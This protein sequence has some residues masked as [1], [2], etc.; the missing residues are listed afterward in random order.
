MKKGK[1]KLQ[2]N[3]VILIMVLGLVAAACGTSDDT[4]TTTVAP[5]TT[6]AAAATTTTAA[7]ETTTTEMVP[8]VCEATIGLMAPITGPVAFIGEVQL[9][10]AKYAVEVWNDGMGWD[11][12]LIEGDTMFDVAQAATL[13]AQFIDNTDIL[14]IVGPAGS[15]QVDAAGAVFEAGDANLTFISPSSTRIGIAEKYAG[16]FR[17]VPT[18]AD[19]GPSTSA[20]MVDAGASKVFMVDD[21]SSYS[22]GLADVTA[23]SLEAAGVEVVRESV[24]QVVTDF[25]ATYRGRWLPTARSSATRWPSR[26]RTSRSSA[27]TAWSPRTSLSPARSSP[28]SL[29]T[30]QGSRIRF[31][32]SRASSSSTRRPTRSGLRC[33]PR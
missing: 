16:M 10:W 25:S 4:T 18:D 13:A 7:A 24:S 22:T 17:T 21:Q 15:D 9:N 26:A 28:P 14:A 2:S 1:R 30:S 5:T 20:F 19:Q 6:A 12:K 29:V 33:S 31:R 23:D 32:C 8:V 3:A 11:V 27:P